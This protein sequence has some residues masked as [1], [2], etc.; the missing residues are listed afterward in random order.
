MLGF[1]RCRCQVAPTQ[2]QPMQWPAMHCRVCSSLGAA[3]C[4]GCA[5]KS[6]TASATI[7][8][9]VGRG[10]WVLLVVWCQSQCCQVAGVGEQLAGVL[11]P[12]CPKQLC[13]HFNRLSC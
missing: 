8:L 11:A 13:L 1:C 4:R 5:M 10:R 6:V 7:L 12:T 3:L 2:R 9:A